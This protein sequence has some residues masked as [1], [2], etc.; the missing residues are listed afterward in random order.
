MRLSP[1]WALGGAVA[2]LA[3]GLVMG[4]A[5]AAAPPTIAIGIAL[6]LG[7]YAVLALRRDRSRLLREA[8]TDTLT[9]LGNRRALEFDLRGRFAGAADH[10]PVVLIMCDL[11]GFKMY[12]DT[13]GRPAGDLLLARFG[14]TVVASVGDLASVYR[15]GADEF[16][17]LAR[18]GQAGIVGVVAA[19]R[20]AL[21]DRGD[22]FA[23]TAACGTVVLPEETAD[24]DEALRLA[25]LRMYEHKGDRPVPVDL[26]TVTVLLR[27]LAER[28]PDLAERLDHTARLTEAVCR[29]LGLP[30]ADRSALGQ[31]A[32]LH[33]IGKVAVPGE[34][35][36]KN[37]PLDD[38]EWAFLRQCP[39]IGERIATAATALAPLAPIIRS[40]R[41]WYDGSGYPDKLVGQAIPLGAR[42]I[43]ACSAVAAMTATRPYA[44]AWDLL[45]VTVELRRLAGAQFDPTVV[46]ALLDELSEAERPMI[47]S[48]P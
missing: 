45:R 27:A 28:D 41:E 48:T 22:G 42:V 1:A 24:P 18:P 2:L 16:A 17:V 23:I 20:A 29:R 7:G 10:D 14:R 15:V 31:A 32:R 9:G 25:D 8:H 6:P 34:I 47:H 35:L 33:D 39:A 13:F 3:G 38:S 36:T 43:A 26:H 44:A 46:A 40:C 30:E 21:R 19:V 12:N 4:L 11:N 5:G 37:G